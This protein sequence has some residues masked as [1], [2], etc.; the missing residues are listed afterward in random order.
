M[1]THRST[2]DSAKTVCL[3][4]S[5]R[6]RDPAQRSDISN[7]PPLQVSSATR[8]VAHFVCQFSL[9]SGLPYASKI[10]PLRPST[11][12]RLLIR[13]Y[14]VRA[15]SGLFRAY[16]PSLAVLPRKTFLEYASNISGW[17]RPI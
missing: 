1:L 12:L 16:F 8:Q 2:L 17:F 14:K 13:I 9:R 5:L 11:L 6:P 4:R 15:R 10:S 3:R 7:L